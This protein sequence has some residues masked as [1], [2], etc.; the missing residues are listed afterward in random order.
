MRF[1]DDSVVALSR[2]VAG[3]LECVPNVSLCQEGE[4]LCRVCSKQLA[5]EID[6]EVGRR[7]YAQVSASIELSK[8]PA[9]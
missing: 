5:D 8:S 2:H 4:R 1:T 9:K 7:V 3:C 6:E